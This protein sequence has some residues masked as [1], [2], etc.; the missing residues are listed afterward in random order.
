M[1]SPLAA[2]LGV[3]LLLSE[4]TATLAS[5]SLRSMAGDC[6]TL[7]SS[8]TAWDAVTR[9]TDWYAAFTNGDARLL[10][11]TTASVKATTTTTSVATLDDCAASCFKQKKCQYFKLTGSDAAKTCTL[12]Q[13]LSISARATP[14]AAS[15]A[16]YG[17]VLSG[18][19]DF[20][21][22]NVDTSSAGSSVSQ[23]GGVSFYKTTDQATS[24][25][26]SMYLRSSTDKCAAVPLTLY[27]AF[28][29]NYQTSSMLSQVASGKIFNSMDAQFTMDKFISALKSGTAV[30]FSVPTD[31]VD[32]D[33]KGNVVRTGSAGSTYTYRLDTFGRVVDVTAPMSYTNV[34]TKIGRPNANAAGATIRAQYC[35]SLYQSQFNKIHSLSAATSNGIP[36]QAGH[37]VGCQFSNPSGF[38]NFVPQSVNSNSNN[39]CWYNSELG[40]SRLLKMGCSGTYHSRMTYFSQPGVISEISNF[41]GPLLSSADAAAFY[42]NTGNDKTSNVQRPCGFF[43]RP[44]KMSF[45]FTISGANDN[46][47]CSLVQDVIKDNG[48]KYFSTSA[49][50]GAV[51]ITR[52]F[53]QW[54]YETNT[55]FRV[56][57]MAAADFR[58]NQCYTET[59]KLAPAMTFE[60]QLDRTFLKLKSTS[61][62]TTPSCLSATSAASGVLTVGTCDKSG[63][64]SRWSAPASTLQLTSSTKLACLALPSALS[65]CLSLS[66]QYVQSA[67]SFSGSTANVSSGDALVDGYVVAGGKCLALSSANVLSFVSMSPTSAC[68]VFQATYTLD[69]G[70]IEDDES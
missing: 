70:N 17:F 38:F 11:D 35:N 69:S 66:F 63:A 7:S 47:R 19:P 27:R 68:T 36:F 44:V 30:E 12:Y 9:C 6:V 42:T 60:N 1:P 59:G 20:L 5:R 34:L 26:I 58:T 50:T 55:F 25:T 62:A 53:A 49:T 37:V 15:T 8:A 67:V 56:R 45:D 40:T 31:A 39:G 32:I 24:K 21:N 16:V 2:V 4:P 64:L 23:L 57:G 3:V 33:A 41:T 54:M 13:H 28:A 61:N 48:G 65:A 52:A 22:Q 18:D 14:L 51:T 43:Y 46:T 29:N 10:E